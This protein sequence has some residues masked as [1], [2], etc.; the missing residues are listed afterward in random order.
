MSTLNS[1]ALSGCA[2]LVPPFPG[3]SPPRHFPRPRYC[4]WCNRL[5]PTDN[6]NFGYTLP[7]V[8]TDALPC[9]AFLGGVPKETMSL[10]WVSTTQTVNC[11]LPQNANYSWLIRECSHI[12]WQ[13]SISDPLVWILVWIVAAPRY[14]PSI[15]VIGVLTGPQAGASVG[16]SRSRKRHMKQGVSF[17]DGTGTAMFCLDS[18]VQTATVQT[19]TAKKLE[20]YTG[21]H[22]G[23]FCSGICP[24]PPHTESRT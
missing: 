5:T 8:N 23:G 1:T 10:M 19:G 20:S 12:R 2:L 21:T 14:K 18:L 6:R 16:R 13:L 11:Q 4:T 17:S 7:R 3:L 24:P 9:L 22:L 15:A